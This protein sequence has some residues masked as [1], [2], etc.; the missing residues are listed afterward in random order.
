[1][2]TKKLLEQKAQTLLLS[3][4]SAREFEQ[5]QSLIVLDPV[6]AAFLLEQF[7]RKL[8][9]V[10]GDDLDIAARSDH[11]VIDYFESQLSQL[12]RERILH[13]AQ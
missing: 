12:V 13:T 5:L 4:L 11:A 9:A 8:T 2:E 10:Q 7:E 1:M 6:A 3:V